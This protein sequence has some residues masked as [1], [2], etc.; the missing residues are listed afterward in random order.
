MAYGP[1]VKRPPKMAAVER[2][3]T[4]REGEE[5]RGARNSHAAGTTD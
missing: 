2:F 4:E 3:W 1:F 5:E